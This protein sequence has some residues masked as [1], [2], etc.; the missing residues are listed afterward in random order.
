MCLDSSEVH[1]IKNCKAKN[2]KFK[3]TF[4]FS[5]KMFCR[6]WEGKTLTR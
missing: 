3:K 6:K 2:K 5:I 1:D 4:Q